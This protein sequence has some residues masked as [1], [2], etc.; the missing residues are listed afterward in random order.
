MDLAHVIGECQR[1]PNPFQY[2]VVKGPFDRRRLPLCKELMDPIVQQIELA[3][4]RHRTNPDAGAMEALSAP[5]VLITGETGTGKSRVLATLTERY[6]GE[7]KSRLMVPILPNDLMQAE[8]TDQV[9]SFLAQRT[10]AFLFETT[11]PGFPGARPIDL[12]AQR[13]A[14]VVCERSAASS[15]KLPRGFPDDLLDAIRA[16]QP[17]NLLDLQ[18]KQPK[19]RSALD[20]L[21]ENIGRQALSESRA[22]VLR[23]ATGLLE[24]EPFLIGDGVDTF[25]R[26]SKTIGVSNYLNCPITYVFDQFESLA[27]G[28]RDPYSPATLRAF[29]QRLLAELEPFEASG[30]TEQVPL[31]ILSMVPG[32]HDL[33]DPNTVHRLPILPNGQREIRIGE[34]GFRSSSKEHCRLVLRAYLHHHW[35]ND[36]RQLASVDALKARP[37]G[38][39]LWPFKADGFAELFEKRGTIRNI[40]DWVN[41]CAEQWNRLIKQWQS[42]TPFETHHERW[43]ADLHSTVINEPIPQDEIV[44]VAPA[45]HVEP[46]KPVTTDHVDQVAID[47]PGDQTK[48]VEPPT[49]EPLKEQEPPPPPPLEEEQPTT[50]RD[51]LAT[52]LDNLRFKQEVIEEMAGMEDGPSRIHDFFMD[53]A[54]VGIVKRVF[55]HLHATFVHLGNVGLL[56]TVSDAARRNKHE[57]LWKE[58]LQEPYDGFSPDWKKLVKVFVYFSVGTDSFGKIPMQWDNKPVIRY[59]LTDSDWFRI[60]ALHRLFEGR[61]FD[62]RG[63]DDKEIRQ[64][65][66]E[67]LLR[68]W[69]LFIQLRE[70]PSAPP[71]ADTE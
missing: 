60:N 55:K 58:N 30:H 8:R 54:K 62:L 64:D 4:S 22:R 70:I 10:E 28:F 67:S 52:L 36:Y 21:V 50:V 20:Y 69:S 47:V 9:A 2:G 24:G 71:P 14:N 44:A 49:D 5:V 12:L 66:I 34:Y 26:L 56:I 19:T 29:M 45:K 7:Q 68:H 46:E 39:G 18:R 27:I 38:D 33:F 42:P 53:L 23:A 59:H 41:R 31:C 6:H 32:D 17:V 15:K 35:E 61:E 48:A 16:K 40:R 43:L 57:R 51:Y 65:V 3:I 13:T 63:R 25:E 37:L 1:L 11:V